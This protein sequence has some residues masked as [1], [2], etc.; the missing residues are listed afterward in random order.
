MLPRIVIHKNVE[1]ILRVYMRFHFRKRKTIYKLNP[2]KLKFLDFA[3]FNKTLLP[4][5][6]GKK[7]EGDFLFHVRIVHRGT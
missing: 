6:N 1:N 4:I 7:K 2:N 5:L 3:V